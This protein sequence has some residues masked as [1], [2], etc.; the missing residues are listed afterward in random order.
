M[1]VVFMTSDC[2]R[3]FFYVIDDIVYPDVAAHHKIS[4]NDLDYLRKCH[5]CEYDIDIERCK[6]YKDERE[7]Y[8]QQP[9]KSEVKQERYNGLTPTPA[10]S[11]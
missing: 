11:R 8:H 4:D 9:R 3:S 7:R 5:Y 1:P 10:T 2:R 6:M